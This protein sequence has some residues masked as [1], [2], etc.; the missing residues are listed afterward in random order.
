MLLFTLS[1]HNPG[2]LT[3]P[4]NNTYLLVGAHD[5]VRGTKRS[6]LID[7]GEGKSEHLADLDRTLAESGA[8]L[9]SVLVTH[10]HVDHISGC[11]AIAA[12]HP[13]AV[14]AKIPWGDRDGRHSVAWLPLEDGQVAWSDEV[15]LGVVHTPG[16][17]PDHACFLDQ[18]HGTLFCGDLLQQNSTVVIPPS[19]GGSL[20]E[21]LRSLQRVAGLGARQLL[22]AHGPPI[23]D[24]IGLI[25]RTVL[26]R[27]AR[28]RRVL[29]SVEAGSDTLEKVV[30]DVYAGLNPALSKFAHET[31]L[32]HLIKLEEDGRLRRTGDGWA[33]A[34]S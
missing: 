2:P 16:H 25:E 14:F 22:P 12:R 23:D 19:G 18:E 13:Q 34:T 9:A 31:A 26:H 27:Q 30:K 28:E 17:S 8:H 3:G 1:A 11:A 33:V 10:G 15:T 20:T 32:A 21:Y 6:V 4:G 24:P 5:P 7:A 29:A